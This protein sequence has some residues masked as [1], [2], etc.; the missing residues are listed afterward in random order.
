MTV[1]VRKIFQL[2]VP[3]LIVAS[4]AWC[5]PCSLPTPEP[6]TFWLMGA[7]AGAILLIRRLRSKK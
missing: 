3:L 6:T 5:Q 2:A 7:G 1:T 4:P